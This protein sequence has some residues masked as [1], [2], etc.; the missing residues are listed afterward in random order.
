[1]NSTAHVIKCIVLS[2]L[3]VALGS[4]GYMTIEGW[5]FADALY[6]TVI[7]FSTVGFKEVHQVS[8]IGQ[9]YT[10]VLIFLGVGFFLYVAGTIIQF[11]IEGRVREIM[12]RRK[13][14]KKILRLK[15]HYIICGYGRIGR[16][17]CKKINRKPFDFVVIEKD[18]ELIPILEED[19]MLY[20]SGDAADEANLIKAGIEKAKGLIAVLATDTDNVFLVLTAR[21]LNAK[22]SIMARA[23][24]PASKM[25]LT[26]AGADIVES[27]YEMGAAR[28]AQR[29]I[30]PAVTSFL[31]QAF[32]DRRTDILMEEIPI[33]PVSALSNVMLKDSGIR[34]KYNLIII[35]I[36]QPDGEMQFNPSFES[37]LKPDHTVIAVGEEENLQALAR[38]LNPS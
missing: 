27:P 15:N 24:T 19:G 31:D 28:M 33:R 17:M 10:I 6:M 9:F 22:L 5:N 13:L 4:L 7:T 2:I 3:L 38:V 29:I 25:K 11:M 21:Q 14:D 20:V 18:P 34:Q 1:M 23:G 37:M 30:R 35:A 8:P 16:V 12:G 36:K 32:A 26:A